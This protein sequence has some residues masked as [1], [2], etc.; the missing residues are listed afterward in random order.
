MGRSTVWMLILMQCLATAQVAGAR[1]VAKMGDLQISSPAFAHKGTIPARHTCDGADVSPL[2]AISGVPAAARSLAL[3]VDD[4][5]APGGVW[6]HWVVWNITPA[7]TSLSENALPP[8]SLQGKNDWGKNGYGGPCPPS[9]SHRYFFKLY[10][11]DSPLKLPASTT[12]K[13]LEMAMDGHVMS[14]GQLIGVYKRR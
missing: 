9:G 7:T 2:L 5:D 10:A 11:L 13:D 4:P 8:G 3:I 1:E 6:V 12:K 14:R